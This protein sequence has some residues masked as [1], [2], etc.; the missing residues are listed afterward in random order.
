[1]TIDIVDD[2]QQVTAAATVM[3]S[4]LERPIGPKAAK[5]MKKEESTT[6]NNVK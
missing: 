4:N 6:A 5:T 2:N 1:M 3:G